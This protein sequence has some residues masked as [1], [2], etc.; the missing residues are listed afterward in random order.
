MM[1]M[2]VLKAG[3]GPNRS[4]SPIEHSKIRR[5]RL[6]ALPILE[7]YRDSISGFTVTT[8]TMDDAF[9]AITGREIRE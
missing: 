1:V 2:G 4:A 7:R 5:E 9:I 3:P 8:G 6:A